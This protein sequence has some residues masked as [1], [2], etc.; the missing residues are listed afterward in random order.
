MTTHLKSLLGT[1]A[2]ALMATMAFGQSFTITGTVLDNLN[3]PV[4]NQPINIFADSSSGGTFVYSNIVTT[5]ASGFYTDVIA[6]GA[7]SGPNIDFIVSTTACA[8]FYTQT[9]ANNQGTTTSGVADFNVCGNTICTAS[10]SASI[11]AL[12]VNFTDQSTNATSY[13]WDFDDG[14]T[15]SSQNPFH[16]FSTS[17]TYNVCLTIT[18]GSCSDTYCSNVTVSNTFDIGGSVFVGM[19]IANDAK[20]YLIEHDAGAGTLT[21]IDSFIIGV[22]DSGYYF[23]G[24]LP[25]GD[26]LT[27]AALNTGDANYSSYVPT[28]YDSDLFWSGAT[29]ITVAP[30]IYNANITMIGGTNSGGAGFVGGLISQCANK[31]QG[32]GDPIENMVVILL[33][34]NGDAVAYDISDANGEYGFD[35]IPFG[36]YTVYAEALNK[37]TFPPTVTVSSEY[38]SVDAVNIQVLA[39]II[40][41]DYIAVGT[42]ELF[43]TELSLNVY[44]NPVVASAT[45]SVSVEENATLQLVIVNTIGKVVFN[46]QKNIVKGDNTFDLS[47]DGLAPGHYIL[48]AQTTD[49]RFSKVVPLL[50]K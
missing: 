42:E 36:T 8:Q 21:A 34:N 50:K 14:N 31:D 44:P 43:E 45:L 23:F 41:S 30:S 10:Y 5:N 16:T 26:Y 37:E 38:S 47:V 9:L 1:V 25:A 17:G 33:D 18:T 28:Y 27:K 11:N 49:G 22:Q 48:K 40:T 46:G 3:N 32:V 7:Q 13:S 15:S 39:D 20:V 35:L 24:G 6:N 2:V 29:T 19:G 4:A 12:D